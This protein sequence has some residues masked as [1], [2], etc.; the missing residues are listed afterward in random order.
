MEAKELKERLGIS[1]KDIIMS[2][3]SVTENREKKITCPFHNDSHPSMSWFEEGNTFVCM[4]CREKLDIYRYY[5]EFEGMEFVEAVK[6]VAN[7]LGINVDLKIPQKK[8]YAAATEGYSPLTPYTLKYLKNRGITKQ[9]AEY[10]NL[11]T[12]QR[13]GEWIVF[14][15]K[16][17]KGKVVFNTFRKLSDKKCQREKDTKEILWGLDKI[18][19]EKPVII[20]EGQFDAMVVSQCGYNNVVSVPSGIQATAWIENSWQFIQKV[21]RFIIW[22]DNDEPGINGAELIR[23]RI[24][25]EKTLVDYHP[26]FKDAND[27]LLSA[28]KEEVKNFIDDLLHEKVEGL[29]NM[30]RRRNIQEKQESFKIGFPEIDRHFKNFKYGQLSVVFGRDNE[31]KS[32]FISQIIANILQTEKVFLYSGELTDD[33]IELWI[34]SQI[35]GRKKEFISDHKNEWGDIEHEITSNAKNAI[36]KW[37]QDRFYSYENKVETTKHSMLFDVME[38]AYKK[39]GI[40]IFFVDNLMSAI[41]ESNDNTNSQETNF[42]KKC[43][44]F[45]LAYNVHVVLIA[46]PNKI[47]SEE[48][49]PLAKVHVNGSKTITNIADNI[50]AVERVWN[51][52]DETINAIYRKNDEKGRR[53]TAII[54]SLKDRVAAGRKDFFFRFDPVSLRLFNEVT[55]RDF[56]DDWQIYLKKELGFIQGG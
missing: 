22:C 43:K 18:D 1:A 16:D 21:K 50:L 20:V 46:H 55:N 41:E 13:N 40:K 11:Q 32:T 15:Y 29:T 23:N 34:M 31:G 36:R 5:T 51:V 49:T 9:T 7:S 4:V 33:N 17:E 42:V 28:G 14:Q 48:H 52:E 45:A 35:V 26:K 8:I 53:Y 44:E 6:T 2:G 47:G 37:Y 12:T 3:L 27:M 19:L 56:S 54:R 38:M 10:W 25:K 24:G 30:G 39:H